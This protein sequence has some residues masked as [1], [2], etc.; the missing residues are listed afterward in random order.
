MR[1]EESGEVRDWYLAIFGGRGTAQEDGSVKFGSEASALISSLPTPAVVRVGAFDGGRRVEWQAAPVHL[2]RMSGGARNRKDFAGNVGAC[3]KHLVDKAATSPAVAEGTNV[4]AAFQTG[5]AETKA[6]RRTLVV[7]TDGLSTTGCADLRATAMRDLAHVERI[8]KACAAQR[9]LPDLRGWTVLLPW[10]GSVGGGRPE[11][12]EPHLVWLRELWRRLCSKAAGAAEH[13]VVDSEEP[14]RF[15][16]EA[17]RAA[18]GAE[19]PEITFANVERRPNAI[20]VEKL[21]SDVLFATDSDR[22]SA[23]GVTLL[24]RFADEVMPKAP[25]WLEVIGH[26]DDQ[27]DASYNEDLSAR[28]AEAV[29]RVLT[30]AGLSGVRVRGMGEIQLECAGRTAEDRKCNRRVEIRYKVR[31]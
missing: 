29:R 27:G 9:A 12:Q 24:K 1:N 6:A 13:C 17:A 21:S 2:P 20:F 16:G 31:G 15:Q 7:A 28:R 4:M 22:V 25:E 10:V 11:P 8:V 3:L 5:R 19:D 26:T 18:E 30:E 23:E 14:P